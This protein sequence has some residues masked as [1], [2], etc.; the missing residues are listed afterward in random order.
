MTTLQERGVLSMPTICTVYGLILD[1]CSV[2]FRSRKSFGQ[3]LEHLAGLES[4][5]FACCQKDQL[6]EGQFKVKDHVDLKAEEL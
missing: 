2:W 3:R 1:S 6:Q 5:A 4:L